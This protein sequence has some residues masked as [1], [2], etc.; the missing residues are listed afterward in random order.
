LK[1][2][3]VGAVFLS[4]NP[5]AIFPVTERFSFMR[6]P[7]TIQLTLLA[8]V[9]VLGACSTT[10][11]TETKSELTQRAQSGDIDA[12]YQLGEKYADAAFSNKPEA[13]YW[14]CLAAREGHVP[15]QMRLAKL[16]EAEAASGY[17][18]TGK[19]RLSN[20]GSAYFWYT[21]AASQGDDRAFTSR[22]A[23]AANMDSA[24]I[25]NV[26]RKATRWQQAGCVKPS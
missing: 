23:L 13:I 7:K 18:I 1:E 6:I 3:G 24:E 5:A 25:E 19:G 2:C 17:N 10:S 4:Y 11:K 26:K 22:V 15:A 21:A 14:L 16:Y 9:A 20:K 8:V 12:R